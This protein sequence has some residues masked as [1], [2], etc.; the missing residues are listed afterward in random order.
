MYF[1]TDFFFFF[2]KGYNEKLNQ[3]EIVLSA[4]ILA[5]PNNTI[6]FLHT[7]RDQKLSDPQLL[8]IV[9]FVSFEHK[10]DSSSDGHLTDF[11]KISKMST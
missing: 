5:L 2:S 1:T 8:E 10:N 11:T 4:I 6:S 3:A 7:C 9:Y